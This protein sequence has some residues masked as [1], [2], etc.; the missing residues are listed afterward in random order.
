MTKRAVNA[1]PVLLSLFMHCAGFLDE[2]VGFNGSGLCQVYKF[3][4]TCNS[5]LRQ[6]SFLLLTLFNISDQNEFRQAEI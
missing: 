1:G 3:D 4:T 6:E 5:D 2:G